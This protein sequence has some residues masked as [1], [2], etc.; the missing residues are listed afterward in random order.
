MSVLS[1]VPKPQSI[2]RG[3]GGTILT[4]TRQRPRATETDARED[5]GGVEVGGIEYDTSA[6]SR[7]GMK[8]E[9][10]AAT[11]LNPSR[12]GRDNH[13]ARQEEELEYRVESGV[14]RRWVA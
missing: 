13:K 14:E 1:L 3:R 7:F 2:H 6:S 4:L 8:L 5:D 11:L 12:D 10:E 9:I